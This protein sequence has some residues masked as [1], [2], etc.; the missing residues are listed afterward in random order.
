L[1]NNL[2]KFLAALAAA[3]IGGGATGA[4]AVFAQPDLV[5]EHPSIIGWSALSGAL[6]GVA[7]LFSRV[8]GAM[9][10]DT[11]PAI[12]QEKEKSNPR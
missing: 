11:T 12:P 7:G 6:V 5:I 1:N 2:K 9:V 3:A 4:G 10:P 8:P